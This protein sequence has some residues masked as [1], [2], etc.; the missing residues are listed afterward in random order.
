MAT[1]IYSDDPIVKPERKKRRKK[2]PRGKYPR[3]LNSESKDVKLMR[4]PWQ[5]FVT[6]SEAAAIMG[7]T[8]ESLRHNY[9]TTSAYAMPDFI[10]IVRNPRIVGLK[11]VGP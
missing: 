4:L 1:P 11:R 8:K 2:Y 3:V 5:T 10:E 7:I 9:L 6:T